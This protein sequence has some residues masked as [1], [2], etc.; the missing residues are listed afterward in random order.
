MKH[1]LLLVASLFV[2]SGCAI[3]NTGSFSLGDGATV[4]PGLDGEL[5]ISITKFRDKDEEEQAGHGSD[6]SPD[7]EDIVTIVYEC[8]GSGA[9]RE[10]TEIFREDHKLKG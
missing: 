9:D 3:G 10:C 4:T 2:L 6:T 7:P 8:I 1:F 5:F